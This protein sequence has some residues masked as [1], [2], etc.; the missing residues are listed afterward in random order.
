MEYTARGWRCIS[1]G[2]GGEAQR[3]H[4][5]VMTLLRAKVFAQ[6]FIRHPEHI[7]GRVLQVR[8]FCNGGW[9]DTVNVYQWAMGQQQHDVT[10]L[11]TRAKLWRTLRTVL[12]QIPGSSKLIVAGDFNCNLGTL[13]AYT[14]PGML[15]P[16]DVTPQGRTYSHHARPGPTS[17]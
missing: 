11:P 1:S 3:A 5:G 14:G 2:I 8:A 7:P 12:G 15:I 10:I 6:D 4:A 16:N 13:A 9:I 17:H